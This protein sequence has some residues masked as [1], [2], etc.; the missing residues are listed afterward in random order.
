MIGWINDW[1]TIIR[2]V[3]WRDHELKQLM[4][5]PPKTGIL[6]FCDRYFIRAGFTNK[7]L[8]DE[9]CRIIYSDTQGS[10]TEVPNVRKNM[11]AFDIYVKQEE[12]HNVGDDRLITRTDL[13]AERLYRLLTSER[14]LANTGYRFWIAGD[15]DLGTRTVG[16]ARKTIAFYYMKVY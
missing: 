4:K 16:Y 12:L 6:Q 13:I 11:I 7:L 14:Y 15:W 10:D 9:V 5:L 3:I 8:S 2:Q 1:N